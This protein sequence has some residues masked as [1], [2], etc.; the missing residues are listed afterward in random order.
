MTWHWAALLAAITISMVG[1][2]LLKAGAAAEDFIAQ[3]LSPMTILGLALYGGSAL[4]YIVALR[5]IPM[6]VALPS[7]AISYV[8]VAIIGYFV[9]GEAFGP[10]KIAAIG[11]ICA[12]VALLAIA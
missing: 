6:S 2:T 10:A 4:L 11:L 1:Q 7:T 12:G 9:F 5:R 8:A 3:L